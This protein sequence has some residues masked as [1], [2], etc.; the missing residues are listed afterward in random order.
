M[1]QGSPD[2]QPTFC[3]TVG[4]D[5]VGWVD[6]ETG[7]T[8]LRP[9]EVNV[10]YALHPDARGKGYATRAVLLLLQH[11]ACVPEVHVARLR[12]DRENGPSLAV[13]RRCGFEEEQGSLYF[14][15]ALSNNSIQLS[16]ATA[17]TNAGTSQFYRCCSCP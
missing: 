5:V 12:I 17:R 2:P 13:A 16:C 8:W 9:G 10:G 3:I 7:P 1:G 6:Y 14:K 11:L 15:K 4:G